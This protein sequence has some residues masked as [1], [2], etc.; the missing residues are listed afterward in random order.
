M[1]LELYSIHAH[2][3][4]A[5]Q[6]DY[7]AFFDSMAQA[8]KGYHFEEGARQ[9]AIGRV[10]SL[11][12]KLFLVAYT[13]Y[14][15]KTVL[16]FDL[17]EQ[18]ELFEATEP[19]R[20]PARKTHVLID[21]QRRLLLIESMRGHLHP[22]DLAVAL[23]A[24]GRKMPG[25]ET[26]E[27]NF[28][29]VADSEFIRQIDQF[30]RI[31]SATVTMARP[32]VDWTER[33]HQL[34]EVADESNAKAIDVTVRSKRGKTLSKDAGLVQFVKQFAALPMSIF[35]RISITGARDED[36]GLITLNLSK[37][38]EH[39]DLLTPINPETGQ[40]NESDVRQN[41]ESYLATKE[42]QDASSS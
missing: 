11:S 5:A 17:N 38:I 20:F 24:V 39:L 15:E 3:D 41:M 12:G 37:H 14:A 2:V 13:G 35:K 30:Q 9:V 6:I 1:R 8:L 40:P 26:L 21:P 28:N 36:G 29:P 42:N 18:K 10:V 19:G 27:L 22:E 33:H 32:N 16:L 34:T 31:Q 7:A 4:T 23:E 25:F